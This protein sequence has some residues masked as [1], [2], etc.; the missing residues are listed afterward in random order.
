MPSRFLRR[1]GGGRRGALV[2]ESDANARVGRHRPVDTWRPVLA[3][4]WGHGRISFPHFAIRF[5]G[6]GVGILPSG[7]SRLLCPQGSEKTPL[8]SAALSGGVSHTVF[9]GFGGVRLFMDHP[10]RAFHRLLPSK[11]LVQVTQLKVLSGGFP[12]GPRPPPGL[13]FPGLLGWGEIFPAG[14]GRSPATWGGSP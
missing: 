13:R 3:A 4:L 10:S 6:W 9:R 14:P 12:F 7:K 5:Q 8:I 2:F 1:W 11:N